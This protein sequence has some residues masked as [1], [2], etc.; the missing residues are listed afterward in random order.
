MRPKYNVSSLDSYES[1]TDLDL[2]ADTTVLGK[3][4]MIVYDTNRTADVSPFLPELGTAEKVRIIIAYDDHPDGET[5]ILIINQALYIPALQDNLVCDIQCRMDDVVIDSCPKS[6]SEN[7]TDDTHTLKFRN[8]NNY[9]IPLDLKG[10]I[11]CFPSRK[12]NKQEYHECQ[13][14]EMTAE[15]PEWNP[16]ARLFDDNENAMT[17]EEGFLKQA[18]RRRTIMTLCANAGSLFD[19]K[20]VSESISVVPRVLSDISNTLNDRLF[21]S[22]IRSTVEVTYDDTV[23][24]KI[25]TES[26][27][28]RISSAK[29]KPRYR[30]TP[31]ILSQKWNI[32]LEAAKRTLRV[33]TQK[34]IKTGADPSIA[35]HWGTNDRPMRYKQLK[36]DLFTDYMFANTVSTRGDTDGQVYTNATDWLKIY[37]TPSKG[38]CHETFDLLAHREGIPDV[39]ISDQAKEETMGQMRKKVR[40]AGVHYNECEP[41]SPFQNRAEAGI[42]EMKRAVKRSMVKKASLMNLWDYCAELQ[43]A[44][45]SDTALDLYALAGLTPESLIKGNTPDMSRLVEHKWY[46]WVK[47]PDSVPSFPDTNEVLGRWLGSSPDIGSE[48]CYHILKET[49]RVIQGT[50]VR[51]LTKAEWESETLKTVRERFDSIIEDKLGKNAKPSDFDDDGDAETPE[52]EAYSDDSD[53]AEPRM[54]E[55]DDYDADTFD[56]Y[57]GAETLLSSGDSMLRGIVKTRKRDADGNPIGKANSNPLLDTRLYNVQFS[58]GNIKEYAANVIAESIYSQV[59]DEGRHHLLLATLV[60]HEKDDTAVSADD[61]YIVTNGNRRRKLMTKGW[62][63]CVKWKDG[64]TSWE[65]LKDLKESNPVEVAEYSVSTKLVSEPA[66]AWWV[67]FTLKRRD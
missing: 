35:R 18:T 55:A 54:P 10:N 40:Q 36:T 22:A 57:L 44:I 64:S 30:L 38:D 8:Y 50:T 20:E 7:P 25:D 4:C 62:K 1:R 60:D 11:S 2:H 27:K 45:R 39:L 16:H 42:R 53:G 24:T 5:I 61:G 43:C 14:I 51:G 49:G 9:T 66:F 3:H 46:D 6:M 32:G 12:P 56:K 31:E 17:D 28:A 13:H 65:A 21:V 48:M 47:F 29:T 15:S 34:G 67:P 58:D 19:A 63:L 59:D 37:P 33:T 23:K 41:Y 26:T 52:F